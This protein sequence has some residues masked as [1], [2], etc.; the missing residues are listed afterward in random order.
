MMMVACM[1]TRQL[2]YPHSGPMKSNDHSVLSPNSNPSS[3]GIDG[4]VWFQFKDESCL[5]TQY[6]LLV[7]AV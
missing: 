6:D 2:P 1:G 5:T 7:A 4:R 3:A